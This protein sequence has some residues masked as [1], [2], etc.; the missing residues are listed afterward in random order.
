MG[1]IQKP[2]TN[3]TNTKVVFKVMNKVIWTKLIV[4]IIFVCSSVCALAQDVAVIELPMVQEDD[5]YNDNWCAMKGVS[6][7]D[8]KCPEGFIAR[9]VIGGSKIDPYF[10]YNSIVALIPESHFSGIP[11]GDGDPCSGVVISE[12]LV[13]TARHCAQKK[14]SMTLKN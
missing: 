12:N 6:D 13:L 9:E 3:P 11:I 10:M 14:K 8:G 7:D 2:V 1:S 5:R 4:F